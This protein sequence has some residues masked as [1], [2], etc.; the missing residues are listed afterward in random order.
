MTRI[1]TRRRIR[2]TRTR[3]T[4]T[5]TRRRRVM[6]RRKTRRRSKEMLLTQKMTKESNN[7]EI[8]WFVIS[9]SWFYLTISE[10][11]SSLSVIMIPRVQQSRHCLV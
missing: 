4:R 7:P 6:E 1:R 9:C 2:R 5:R 3:K 10:V 11:L 8:S